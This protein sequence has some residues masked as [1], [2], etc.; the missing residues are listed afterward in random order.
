[1]DIFIGLGVDCQ[2]IFLQKDSRLIS[3]LKN[4]VCTSDIL[5]LAIV[6]MKQ[7][8]FAW[9]VPARYLQQLY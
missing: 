3:L 7:F 5:C 1:M 8:T 6:I 2:I 9:Q 4:F